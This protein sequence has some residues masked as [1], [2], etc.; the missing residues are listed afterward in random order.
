MRR[1]PGIDKS[2]RGASRDTSVAMSQLRNQPCS[3]GSGRRYKYCCGAVAPIVAVGT[4]VGAPP[5]APMQAR[6]DTTPRK[7]D[8]A[9]S[10]GECTACCEGPMTATIRG[11]AIRPGT[12]CHFLGAGGCTIYAERP[13]D[14]CRTFFC[15]WRLQG[16][17]FPDAL[18]PDRSGAIVLA[19]RWRDRDAYCLVTDGREPDA[20]MLDWMRAYSRATGT[21]FLVRLAGRHRAYGPAEFQQDVQERAARGAPLLDGLPAPTGSLTVVA[22]PIG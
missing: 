6:Q 18:R 11:H 22:L 4:E 17:P 20:G 9:R 8:P 19:L 5:T 21:P 10:C 7:P 1:P 2:T 15:A 16:N 14:P 3:C 12:P 13:H